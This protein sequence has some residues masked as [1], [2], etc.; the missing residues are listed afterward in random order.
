MSSP[1]KKYQVLER[2]VL[3]LLFIKAVSNSTM[4]PVVM[5]KTLNSRTVSGVVSSQKINGIR[6]VFD[7]FSWNPLSCLLACLE[8]SEPAR[9]K[10]RTAPVFIGLIIL[11]F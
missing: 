8:L 4:S 2:S 11:V 1:L 5:L 6:F 9:K 7:A 3:L 10:G